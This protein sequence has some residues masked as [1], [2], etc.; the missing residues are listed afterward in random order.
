MKHFLDLSDFDKTTIRKI[1]DASHAIKQGKILNDQPLKGKTVA[2]VFEKASTRTRVSF[3]VGLSDFGANSAILT[4]SETQL[5]RGE[6]VADTSRVLSHML[7]GI[8]LRTDDHQKLLEMAEHATVPV[9]NGL[10]DNSHPCQIMADIM[11]LEEHFKTPIAGKKIAW[12][13]DGNNVCAS[14]AQ[15]T[16]LFG[17]ELHIATP[18][19]YELPQNIVDSE[20]AKGGKIITSHDPDAIIANADVVVTDTWVS[21]GDKD[22]DQRMQAFPPY[23]VNESRMKLAK[24][25]AVFLHCLPAH[26]GEEATNEVL[27]GKQSLI[28]PEAGNRV[29][30]QKGIIAYCFGLLDSL[31]IPLS[32]PQ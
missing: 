2:L 11:T 12:L 4:S 30:A 5:G 22:Y 1:M 29:N 23:Q 9:I 15:A 8:M 21:M 32:I 24:P 17:F 6:T 20:Q 7:D 26:R 27:D 10:T 16:H 18:P 31:D 28:F 3:Q 13:G 25:T 14:F 19:N